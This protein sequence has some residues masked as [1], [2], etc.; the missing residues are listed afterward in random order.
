M[1]DICQL[2]ERDP[3]GTPRVDIQ[4]AFN[5]HKS[6]FTWTDLQELL[7]QLPV[8]DFFEA[9]DD[10]RQK[11]LIDETKFSYGR[12]AC[13]YL[14]DQRYSGPK[15]LDIPLYESIY[16]AVWMLDC[17]KEDLQ[18]HIFRGQSNANW[19][20]DNTLLRSTSIAPLNVQSLIERVQ[21]TEAF[22]A[23][24]RKHQQKF[25]DAKLKEQ[26]LLAIAQHYGFPTPLLDFTKSHRIAAF[27]ATLSARNLQKGEERVGVIYYLHPA[28]QGLEIEHISPYDLGTFSLLN[29]ARIRLG[30][31]HIIE[32]NITDKENRITRQQGVFLAGYQVRDLQ[33]MAIDRVYFRQQPGVVFEDEAAQITEKFLLSDQSEVYRLAKGLKKRFE[34]DEGGEPHLHSMIAA[35]LVPEMSIIGSSGEYLFAQMREAKEFF[36]K[37]GEHIALMPEHATLLDTLSDIFSEYFRSSMALAAVGELPATTSKREF[38]YPFGDAVTRLATIS[39]VDKEFLWKRVNEY[40]PNDFVSSPHSTVFQDLESK[41]I[42][43]MERIAIACTFYLAGWERLKHIEGNTARRLTNDALLELAGPIE[44]DLNLFEDN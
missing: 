38:L 10:L 40:I 9:L 23:E 41:S 28:T 8:P 16:D 25:F 30:T 20:L 1:K 35:T 19:R 29:E 44:I 4:K 31:L 5:E 12:A 15:A 6:P 27:F 2:H 22:L 7:R 13:D 39:N 3:H 43:E 42:T 24:L 37:L 18:G 14:A 32:P 26:E 34:D 17:S 11:G 36:R 33:N 21:L